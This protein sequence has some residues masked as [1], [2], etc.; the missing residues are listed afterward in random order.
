ML[1]AGVF[2]ALIGFAVGLLI[3]VPSLI[4]LFRL[5]LS[6]RFDPATGLRPGPGPAEEAAA[7]ADPAAH[8]SLRTTLVAG[9]VTTLGAAVTFISESAVPRGIG[10]AVMLTGAVACFLA[11]ASLDEADGPL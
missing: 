8:S 5:V 3:L 2:W 1:P 11:V 6:G 10:V 9:G 7:N 4:Y